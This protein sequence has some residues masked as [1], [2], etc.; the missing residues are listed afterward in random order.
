MQ[1]WTYPLKKG[2]ER[3]KGNMGFHFC[4]F[5]NRYVFSIALYVYVLCTAQDKTGE[6][7]LLAWAHFQLHARSYIG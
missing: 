7:S 1:G 5:V 3:G 6:L 4:V 2:G